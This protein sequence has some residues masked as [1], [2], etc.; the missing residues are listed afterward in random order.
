MKGCVKQY[1]ALLA[2][3]FLVLW[4]SAPVPES[5][6]EEA[7]VAE[8]AQAPAPHKTAGIPWES[9]PDTNLGAS[10]MSMVKGLA[11]CVAILLIGAH[12][13]RRSTG[14][15]GAQGPSRQLKILER[16]PLGPRSALLLLEVRGEPVLVGLTADGMRFHQLGRNPLAG[17]F[18]DEIAKACQEPTQSRDTHSSG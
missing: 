17:D 14:Q 3:A 8:T 2:V 7:P 16:L 1:L 15:A 18:T 4:V 12:L 5:Y 11:L 13:Y 9:A 6:A 10:A